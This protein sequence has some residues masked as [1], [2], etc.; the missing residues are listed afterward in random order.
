MDIKTLKFVDAEKA[1][2][3]IL[4][5]NV[6]LRLKISELKQRIVRIDRIGDTAIK[7]IQGVASARLIEKERALEELAKVK[8][9]LAA[10]K[11]E[12]QKR[13]ALRKRQDDKGKPNKGA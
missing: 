2:R 11:A 12:M 5:D 10:T 9:E 1:V 3:T 7:E 6:T 8:T 4:S 13:E